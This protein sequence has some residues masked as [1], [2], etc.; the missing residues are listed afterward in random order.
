MRSLGLLL[1]VIAAVFLYPGAALAAFPGENGRI[2]FSR[3]GDIFTMSP[4][5]S[6]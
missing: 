3:D 2:S 4:D 1:V 5:G 6:D